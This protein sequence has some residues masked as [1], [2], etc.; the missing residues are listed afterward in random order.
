MEG[1]SM[2]L[3][4]VAVLAPVLLSLAC[5]S[6]PADS[7]AEAG[8]LPRAEPGVLYAMGAGLG[9]QVRTYHFDEEEVREVARGMSD[10]ALDQSIP[11][12]RTAEIGEQLARFHQTRLTELAKREKREGEY[13]LEQALRE[14]GAVRT[15]TGMVLR[16][17][18][19]GSGPKPTIFDIVA[20]NHR[21]TLR[22]GT[23]F[24]TNEG[25]PPDRSQLGT[26]TRCWQEALGAVA[27]GARL[28]I[29]CPPEISYG[30]GGW[31]GVVPGGAV[32]SYELE[33]VA[34]EQK[35]PPP[36]WNPEW[37]AKPAPPLQ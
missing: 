11:E 37:D 10:A 32:V 17:I 34:V 1:A 22:D 5:T 14:P 7:P 15:E 13:L 12:L 6:I 30:W 23:V 24:H 25:K 19:P 33:L 28:H 4:R 36:N 20:V 8:E 21:G 26:D 16:I 29:V 2:S 18:E 35:A 31:A 3:S 27:A 9:D